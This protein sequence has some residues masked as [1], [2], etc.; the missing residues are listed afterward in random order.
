VRPLI[1]H[2]LLCRALWYEATLGPLVLS[3]QA[4]QVA[5]REDDQLARAIVSSV[6]LLNTDGEAAHV[7]AT[8]ESISWQSGGPIAV[9][10]CTAIAPA[11]H[12]KR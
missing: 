7:L 8:V 4:L 2:A 5:T 9:E 6:E 1:L 11:L 12:A 3:G 10:A